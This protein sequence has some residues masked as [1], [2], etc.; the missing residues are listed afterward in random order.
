M[1]WRQVW[2]RWKRALARCLFGAIHI[3]EQPLAT[4]SIPQSSRWG[5][6]RR[7]RQ[8][9]FQKQ[10][11]QRFHAGLIQH[12]QVSRQGRRGGKIGSAKQRSEER[13]VGKECRSRWA[14]YH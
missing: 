1:G 7:A 2:G 9:V 6:E 4:Q 5:A 11:A 13:R 8:Q 14:P 12:R 3:D 10:G